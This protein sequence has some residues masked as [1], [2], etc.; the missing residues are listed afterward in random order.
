[1][2]G[3]LG[4]DAPSRAG[5]RS[6]SPPADMT[7]AQTPESLSREHSELLVELAVALHKSA[8]YPGGHPLLQTAVTALTRN[9]AD[10]LESHGTISIGVARHQLV[11][12]GIAT[13]ADHPHLRALAQHLHDQQIGA[14]RFSRGIERDE[15]A[16]FLQAVAADGIR[17]ETPLGLAGP[18][19]LQRWTHAALFPMAFDQL[20]LVRDLDAGHDATGDA[21]Q[22]EAKT[23]GGGLWV[24]LA[25]AAL[26]GERGTDAATVDPT[27]VAGAIDARAGDGAYDQ[28]IVGY[29]VQI[30]REVAGSEGKPSASLQQRISR[31]LGSMQ[32]SSLRRLLDMGG[33][34][35]QRKQFVLDAAHG[36]AASAVVEVVKAA[37]DVS[38]FH[39]SSPLM[40]LLTKLAANADETTSPVRATADHELRHQVRS[41]LSN[42]DL[43]DPNPD[44]YSTTLRQ[45]AGAAHAASPATE[46]S[47]CEPDRLIEIALDV[48][49]ASSRPS[50]AST[51]RRRATRARRSSTPC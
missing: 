31:L 7:G 14:M 22:R 29:L 30:A 17:R 28:V 38:G 46:R 16:S 23:R 24:G 12:E 1:M 36:F 13:N 6:R 44:A 41:L 43:T 45:I 37:A 11:I 35:S 51:P 33:D 49:R 15:L 47:S 42:W 9:L 40:R 20:E 32:S 26:A 21:T 18:E 19:V 5:R 48:A 25:Q 34:A 10:A 39:I 50:P 8:I 3:G 4:R 2:Q 27:V